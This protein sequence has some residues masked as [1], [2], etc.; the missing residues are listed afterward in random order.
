MLNVELLNTGR[1][2]YRL[3]NSAGPDISEVEKFLIINCIKIVPLH[4][5]A[6]N[7]GQETLNTCLI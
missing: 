2:V 3:Q 6:H 4:I 7:N 1:G 5:I